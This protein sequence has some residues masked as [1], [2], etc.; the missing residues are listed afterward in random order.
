M[1]EIKRIVRRLQNIK[2][3]TGRVEDFATP[4]KAYMKLSILEMEKFR[5]NKEKESALARLRTIDRRFEEIEKDMQQTLKAMDAREVVPAHRIKRPT[6]S[7]SEPCQDSGSFR[8][9]Y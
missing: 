9:R 8:I 6:S 2:T 1:P 5:R 4:Y 7:A 3:L